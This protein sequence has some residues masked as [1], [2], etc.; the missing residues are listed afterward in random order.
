ME[1]APEREDR[2]LQFS[3]DRTQWQHLPYFGHE[4]DTW[5][6]VHALIDPSQK[7]E[8]DQYTMT[9]ISQ[10]LGHEL[11]REAFTT[12]SKN[13]RS[14]L[15]VTMTAL[16]VGV[17][18]YIADLVPSAEWLAFHVPTPPVVKILAE[19]L[20]TLPSRAASGVFKAPPRRLLDR[21]S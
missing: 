20:P 18:E 12:R 8:L 9:G 13:P 1:A 7:V 4:L 15:L 2:G 14:S 19:Y 16:E 17:K 10:P 6:E 21:D 5:S 3:L 11:L